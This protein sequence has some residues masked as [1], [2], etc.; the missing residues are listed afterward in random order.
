MKKFIAFTVLAIAGVAFASS[1]TVPWFV[2]TSGPHA[3]FPPKAK[4]SALV[5]LH[6]NEAAYLTCTISY[7]TKNGVLIGSNPQDTTFVIPANATLAFR[8]CAIDPDSVQGGQES[9]TA[10]LIPDRPM[11]TG[12]ALNGVDRNDDQ[13]NGALFVKW[14]K[15]DL[16]GQG[17]L[18]SG[19]VQGFLVQ[20]Q[21][22][23][24]RGDSGQP[25]AYAHWGTLLPSGV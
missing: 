19:S 10:R 7:V 2:D 18:G 22:V 25:S 5:Y 24:A 9:D 11:G 13:P 8:P 23:A 6:N 12:L 4:T 14:V 21:A 17:T 15:G 1:L 3:F 20:S 16:P